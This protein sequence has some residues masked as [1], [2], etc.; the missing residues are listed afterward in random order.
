[1]GGTSN[2]KG[3]RDQWR[4]GEP[5]ELPVQFWRPGISGALRQYCQEFWEDPWSIIISSVSKLVLGPDVSA[6]VA[7]RHGH[8]PREPARSCSELFTCSHCRATYLLHLLYRFV[9]RWLHLFLLDWWTNLLQ[10]CVVL[11]STSLIT[12]KHV[13]SLSQGVRSR[14][15][16]L[17]AIRYSLITKLLVTDRSCLAV[18]F[19]WI[20][21]SSAT[22]NGLL[23]LKESRSASLP[24]TSSVERG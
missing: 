8:T 19:L 22:E 17:T 14:L 1:M 4:D 7:I 13:Q 23:K 18:E 20:A 9:P 12:H 5:E 16:E 6:A 21:R 15:P 24:R 2:W 3:G 11:R 10:V